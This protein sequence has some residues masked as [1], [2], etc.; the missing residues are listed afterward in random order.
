MNMIYTH[1]LIDEL[2]SNRYKLSE[3]SRRNSKSK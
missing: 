2:Y 1:F 3:L